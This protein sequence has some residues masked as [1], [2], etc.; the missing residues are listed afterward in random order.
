MT[1]ESEK[2]ARLDERLA[3]HIDKLDEYAQRQ[4]TRHA[5]LCAQIVAL[6][7]SVGVTDQRARKAHDRIDRYAFGARVVVLTGGALF[8]GLAAFVGWVWK[9][10]ADMADVVANLPRR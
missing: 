2:L 8:T 10:A 3:N 7:Q 1:E 4:E 9:H 6:A 5:E